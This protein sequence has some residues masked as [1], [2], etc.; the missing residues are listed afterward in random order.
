MNKVDCL[1]IGDHAVVGL[2]TTGR[3]YITLKR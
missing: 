1:T 3:D 2:K